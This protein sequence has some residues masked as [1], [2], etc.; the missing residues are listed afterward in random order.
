M[1]LSI[2]TLS[3]MT[4]SIMALRIVTF[5]RKINIPRHSA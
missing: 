4:L 5:S 1:T 2:M 3:I